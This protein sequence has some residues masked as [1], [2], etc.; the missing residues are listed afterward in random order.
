M[1]FDLP[2]SS[3]AVRDELRGILDEELGGRGADFIWS[4][5]YE[6]RKQF[7]L[8]LCTRLGARG[9][10]TPHW[11]A[12]YGGRGGSLFDWVVLNEEM[13]GTAEPRG[14]QYMNVNWIGPALLGFGS[15]EQKARFL[16]PMAAGTVRWCQGFSETEA[17]SDLKS[18][19]TR[20]TRIGDGYRVNGGKIWTSYADQADWAIVLAKETEAVADDPAPMS[21]FMVDMRSPGVSVTQLPTIVPGHPVHEMHFDDVAVPLDCRL[22]PPGGAWTIARHCLAN[23]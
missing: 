7:S 21:L 2:A 6:E 10:L 3:V 15:E 23:E 11:P 8:G 1:D 16:P 4:L 12:E 5:G 14:P 18:L 20:A 9:L 22:G 17:G 19:R 13:L